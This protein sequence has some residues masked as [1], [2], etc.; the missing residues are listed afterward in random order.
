LTLGLAAGDDPA[1]G[2]NKRKM[3]RKRT[4]AA[5]KGVMAE[6]GEFAPPDWNGEGLSGYAAQ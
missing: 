6:S 4:A 3:E 2:I 1:M 5:A